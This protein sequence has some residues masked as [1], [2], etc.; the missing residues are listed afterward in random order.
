MARKRPHLIPVYD[1]VV[2]CALN[3]PASL[4]LTLHRVLGSEET[5]V[6][7]RLRRVALQ[8]SGPSRGGRTA[9]SST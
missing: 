9:A 7:E 4:W 2:R 3:T 6:A 1:A 5:G 8:L